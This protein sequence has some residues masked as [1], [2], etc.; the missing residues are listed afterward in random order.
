MLKTRVRPATF[1]VALNLLAPTALAVRPPRHSSFSLSPPSV[2]RSN[3][4]RFLHRR[5]RQEDRLGLLS[6]RGGGDVNV[7]VT[8]GPVKLDL[9]LTPAK[10]GAYVGAAA[11]A[12]LTIVLV[13]KIP[14]SGGHAPKFVAELC[15]N[16]GVSEL[17]ATG[18]FH[19]T[20]FAHCFLVIAIMPS[21]L[22]EIVFGPGGV[23]LLG[24]VFPLV[25]S[26]KAAAR[27]REDSAATSQA[28]LMYWVMH[29]IFSF[30]SHDM[31]KVI[32]RFGPRGGK[33][34][35]EFQFYS[36]C[37]FFGARPSFKFLVHHNSTYLHTP[38]RHSGSLA[39]FALHRRF[40]DN[41]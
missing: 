19:L 6:L 24:T 4:G 41:L 33:H 39:H 3:G 23:I 30:A 34:W 18:L 38:F 21:R 2:R 26:I 5:H 29:G 28:W 10:V 8:D 17:G 37:L 13:K 15:A 1:L 36:E 31:A 40:R 27:S 14:R 32:K 9:E 7:A 35:F 25:E 16:L 11:L 12:A 22:K 20:Y